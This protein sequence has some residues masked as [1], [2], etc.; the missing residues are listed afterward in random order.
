[1][2]DHVDEGVI[3]RDDV[4]PFVCQNS[5]CGKQ[6]S[7]KEFVDVLD[8]RGLV[9]AEL[10]GEYRDII[11]QGITCPVCKW[12]N[13]I[14]LPKNQPIVDL[15]TFIISPNLD[16][17]GNRYEQV[18]ET[19]NRNNK[20]RLL[21]FN[22]IPAWDDKS[23]S[24]AE[25][26]RAHKE[27]KDPD[28]IGYY[29]KDESVPYLFSSSEEVTKRVAKEFSTG[30]IRLRRLYPDIPRF[31]Y[32]L[33]C[34]SPSRITKIEFYGESLC[35]FAED[36]TPKER[37]EICQA[38]LGLLEEVKG[39]SLKKSAVDHLKSRG[40]ESFDEH[41]LSLFLDHN[42]LMLRY[43][44]TDKLRNFSME[45]GFEEKIWKYLEKVFDN[46][47]CKVCTE[48]ALEPKREQLLDWVEKKG[49]GK[50]LFVD[51]AI[52][53]GKTYSIVKVLADKPDTSA[54]IFM[55]TLKLCEEE[56]E[57]LKTKI[58]MNKENDTER[59]DNREQVVDENEFV[60]TD[61]YGVPLY[62]WTREFLQDEVYF[63]D[64][65]NKEE[66]INFRKIIGSYKERR[67][68]KKQ[69]YCKKCKKAWNSTCRFLKHDELAKKA[70]IVVTTHAQY[71][72]FYSKSSLHNWH[73]ITEEDGQIQEEVVKRDVF[74]IDEDMVLSNCY[75]PEAVEYD[76]LNGFVKDFCDFLSDFDET[77]DTIGKIEKF[78]GKVT[79][80][81][82]N[83][84]IPPIDK[85]F[86]IPDELLEKWKE[87][88]SVEYD[89][90]S[91]GLAQSHN[92]VDLSE[93]LAHAIKVGAVVE[94]F[95][96]SN[97]PYGE[98]F[99]IH[100]A[101][102]K[103][104]DL[105]GLPPHAFFDGTMLGNRFL[106]KKLKNIGFERMKIKVRPLWKLRVHQNIFTDLPKKNTSYDKSR[107]K[108]FVRE[109]INCLQT[110]DAYHKYFFLTSK[111]TRDTYFSHF[112]G[113]EFPK[114]DK[115]LCHYRYMKGINDAKD[116][117]IGI[118]LGS[119]IMPIAAEFAM[120]LEF[121]QS[122][123][124]KHG[125]NFS[126]NKTYSWKEKN[127]KRVFRDNYKVVGKLGD[128]LRLSEHHQGI[129]RTRYIFHDVDFYVLSK[130]LV[131]DYEELAEMLTEKFRIDLFSKKERSDSEYRIFKK[132][133][134]KWLSTHDYVTIVAIRKAANYA[135]GTVRTHLYR[136]RD[137][138][139]L[140]RV[141]VGREW[142]YCKMDTIP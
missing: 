114:L 108:V 119:Y 87:D 6:Y 21:W 118:M 91:R 49:K 61:E 31:R 140:R 26:E 83:T 85:K 75:Q 104:Y 86:S 35:I 101:N 59:S 90:E 113:K 89:F 45:I 135:R 52:G 37:R 28:S 27:H 124:R 36:N 94:R 22:Y 99:R 116:C 72:K 82:E 96:Q 17:T 19:R 78:L 1:M 5:A 122:Q 42:L 11:L 137:E 128:T 84:V 32:L 105:S 80:C 120:A 24:F 141:K 121:V 43:E 134:E 109:L 111:H 16:R 107:V 97:A 33:K 54:V 100:F 136:M 65:I 92:R 130:D 142:R 55:P 127:A 57:Q 9:Y 102:P 126:L 139:L 125:G 66:C 50:A 76:D 29:S 60:V 14:P 48:I 56:V 39:K 8:R 77:A 34:L 95:D 2:V 68:W 103:S 3:L 38:W 46:V 12:T 88:L 10:Y 112:L 71:D 13:L 18:I 93:L 23:V 138:K 106:K 40:Y 123:L 41:W 117:D 62:K 51:A 7:R 115:V 129:A 79:I 74:I 73:K 47:F 64:G 69:D 133:V 53:L 4:F 25:I 30:R 44:E 70:R 81:K 110:G 63:V 132:H 131:R 15:R 20:S 67:V 98:R 58:D